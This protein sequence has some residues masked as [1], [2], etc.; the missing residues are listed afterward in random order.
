MNELSFVEPER[1]YA[2]SLGHFYFSQ[3]FRDDLYGDEL[4][5][6]VAGF[7]PEA[8]ISHYFACDNATDA[9]NKMLFADSM[10]RLPDHSV[11]ILDR[12]TM[13][14]SLE[15]RSPFMD[16]KLAEYVATLPPSLKVR[17]RTRRYIQTRVAERYVSPEILHRKKI[18]F[19]SALPYLL[20]DEYKNLYETFLADSHLVRDGYLKQGPVNNLIGQHLNKQV[21]HGNRLWLLCNSEVW[22]RMAIEGWSPGEIRERLSPPV[23][24]MGRHEMAR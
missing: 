19:S 12:A 6:A 1:R 18:G 23:T 16:H 22:Y 14:H 3:K 9:L 24:Q 8:Q 15:A 13:A 11:M 20:G 2:R 5:R 7:D 17:G 4:N 10:I 21:D